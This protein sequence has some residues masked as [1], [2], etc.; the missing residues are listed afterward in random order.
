MINTHTSYLRP[1]P[2]GA[3]WII[4]Y[5][6]IALV[7]YLYISSTMGG[8][9]QTFKDDDIIHSSHLAYR[10]VARPTLIFYY[11]LPARSQHV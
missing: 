4:R 8:R 2:I 10:L 3:A 7:S 5:T 9:Q 1:D 11:L 6:S